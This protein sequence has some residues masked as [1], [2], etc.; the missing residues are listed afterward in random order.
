MIRLGTMFDNREIGKRIR[1]LIDGNY[2]CRKIFVL[3]IICSGIF[4]YFGPPFIQWIFSS[5]RESTQGKTKYSIIKVYF[6]FFFF[7]NSINSIQNHSN[8]I[9]Y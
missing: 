3:L 1:R 5:T 7:L 9:N 2:S 4:L 8:S 6:L